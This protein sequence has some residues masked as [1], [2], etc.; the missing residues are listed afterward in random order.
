MFALSLGSE[1]S[2]QVGGNLSTDAGGVNVLKY[3]TARAQVLGLE[4]VLADGS[5]VSSLR[6]LRKDT[7]GYDLK[8]LFIG[9]EGTLGIITAAT[10]RLFP[11][12]AGKCT[13]LVAIND[14]S[15]AVRLLAFLRGELGDS[16]EAFRADA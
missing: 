16:I 10:L 2:C 9:S 4:A 8:Q 15:D 7:A 14:A 5:V 12:P 6:S 3:G 13:A 1:G 11:L